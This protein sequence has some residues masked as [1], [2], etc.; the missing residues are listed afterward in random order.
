MARPKEVGS[1]GFAGESY[2]GINAYA[3]ATDS[4][5]TFPTDGLLGDELSAAADALLAGDAI[6]PEQNPSIGCNVKW[7]A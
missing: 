3:G 7:R 1:P 4:Y 2:R 5:L 6:A